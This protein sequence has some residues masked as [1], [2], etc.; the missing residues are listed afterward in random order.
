MRVNVTPKEA[1]EL[2]RLLPR[3]EDGHTLDRLLEKLTKAIE[4]HNDGLNYNNEKYWNGG[5]HGGK[6]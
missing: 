4:R 6:K 5:R 3:L 1:Q 2:A